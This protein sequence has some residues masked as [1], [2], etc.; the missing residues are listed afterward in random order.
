MSARIYSSRALNPTFI[1]MRFDADWRLG[2]VSLGVTGQVATYSGGGAIRLWNFEVRAG[3]GVARAHPGGIQ[4]R[5]D[6]RCEHP[7]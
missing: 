7:Q 5:R 3:E 6:H 2:Q 4:E 1:P